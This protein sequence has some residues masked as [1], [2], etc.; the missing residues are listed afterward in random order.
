MASKSHCSKHFFGGHALYSGCFVSGRTTVSHE[1]NSRFK[2]YTFCNYS[3]NLIS[4]DYNFKP[5]G[6][7]QMI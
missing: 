2:Y 1:L 3:D 6:S 7:K 5:K 4:R